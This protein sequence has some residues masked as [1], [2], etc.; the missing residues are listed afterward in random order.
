MFP[1]WWVWTVKLRVDW[2]ILSFDSWCVCA[3]GTKGPRDKVIY[4]AKN[5]NQSPTPPQAFLTKLFR[6]GRGVKPTTSLWPRTGRVRRRRRRRRRRGW[7]SWGRRTRRSRGALPPINRWAVMVK[8]EVVEQNRKNKNKKG[9]QCNAVSELNL[10]FPPF[11]P[12]PYPKGI[13]L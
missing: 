6:S 9:P 3:G 12:F 11:K 5:Q 8:S 4:W 10:L 2:L 1:L 13:T 7:R